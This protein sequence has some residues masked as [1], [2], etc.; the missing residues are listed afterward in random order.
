MEARAHS[1]EKRQLAYILARQQVRFPTGDDALDEVMNNTRLADQFEVLAKELDVVEPKTAEDVYKSQMEPRKHPWRTAPWAA[2]R[3][4]SDARANQRCCAPLFVWLRLHGASGPA[5]FGNA[6]ADSAKAN[7]AIS[8]VNGFVNA[9]FRKDKLL[10]TE[11]GQGWIFK[12]KEHGRC[13]RPSPRVFPPAP[14][15]PSRGQCRATPS[16]PG[17]P[18]RDVERDRRPRPRLPVGR[19]CRPHAGRQVPVLARGYD[20]STW[21]RARACAPLLA[22]GVSLALV[23]VTA[24]R[25]LAHAPVA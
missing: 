20:Q 8:F 23:R 6:Q 4:A 18:C 9:G 2:R 21:R 25:R 12:H 13:S 1:V 24:V 10:T 11:D 7:L 16:R 15:D 19:R 5:L 14:A 17:S 3:I 22:H